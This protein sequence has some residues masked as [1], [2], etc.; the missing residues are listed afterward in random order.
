MAADPTQLKVSKTIRLKSM[1]MCIARLPGSERLFVGGSDFKVYEIPLASEKPEPIE[2]QGDGHQS[3]VTGAA[4]ANSRLI[5]GSYDGQLIWWDVE[6]RQPVRRIAAHDKWIRKVV[7]SPDGQW[8][9]S[10]ADDMLCKI[11]EASTGRLVHTLV[12]HKPMT[13]H[14]FPSMLFAVAWSADGQFLATG[15]K[16]GHIAVWESASGKKLAELEAPILYTWDPKQRRHSIGGIR[17]LAFSHDGRLIAAGGIGT[18]G[19]VDHLDGPS[20]VEIFDWR[21]QQR[22]H[23][24]SDAAY[25]G[26][27][28]QIAFSSDS[29]WIVFAGGDHGGFVS[30]YDVNTGKLIHQSK[31]PMHVHGFVV[32]ETHDTLYSAGHDQLAVVEFK[33]VSPA[34]A[35]DAPKE[36]ADAPAG[37][38]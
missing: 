22:I 10:V 6:Q 15:D 8:V 17:S 3:Y 4:I 12:E 27:V 28:E 31:V 11:W 23:E 33:A 35:P 30:F 19:N 25:K 38:Q 7:A 34:A 29:A 26:L 16:V 32:N 1:G 18:I 2:F 5:T 13:P 36:S 37:A 21:T 9:A 20:R 24:I 14:H